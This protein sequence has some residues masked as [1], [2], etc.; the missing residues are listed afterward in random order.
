MVPNIDDALLRPIPRD[1]EALRLLLGYGRLLQTNRGPT[2]PGLLRI[3]AKHVRDLVAV[4]LGATG[5]AAACAERGG[6]RAARLHAIKAD[7]IARLGRRDGVSVAAIA[8]AAG[9]TPRY[10]QALF[11]SE[12]TTFSAFVLRQRLAHAHRLLADT[13]SIHL[14]IGD[15]A[16]EAGFNDLSYFNR[17]FR[18][19]YGVTPSEL[20]A[21]KL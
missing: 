10:V 12:G 11:E 19:Q 18:R 6:V 13:G 8:G 9:I 16:L 20:R 21:I 1:N 7:I 14:R 17:A 15:V 5:D 2:S 3:A 4:A